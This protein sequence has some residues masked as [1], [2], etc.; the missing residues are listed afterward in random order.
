MASGRGHGD[1]IFD[2]KFSPTP[3]PTP[4]L[5][6][7]GVKH[8]KFWTMCG[9]TLTGRKGVFGKKGMWVRGQAIIAQKIS[10]NIEEHSKHTCTYSCWVFYK[11]S[12][13]Y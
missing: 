7:C 6:T 10:C 1:R 3:S 2:I 9:N 4:I 13:Y 12:V 5:V 11:Y 8:I